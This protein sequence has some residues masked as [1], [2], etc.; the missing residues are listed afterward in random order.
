MKKLIK[1][2][3]YRVILKVCQIRRKVIRDI[4]RNN[5]FTCF[6]HT[7]K[8]LVTRLPNFLDRMIRYGSFFSK[9]IVKKNLEFFNFLKVRV[10]VILFIPRTVSKHKVQLLPSKVCAIWY[11]LNKGVANP[12]PLK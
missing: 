2:S 6:A 11:L 10:E 12:N 3:L 1:Y 7:K 8:K 5:H 9:Y 4:N